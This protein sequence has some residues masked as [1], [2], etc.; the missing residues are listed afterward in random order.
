[1]DAVEKGFQTQLG[2]IQTKT[3]RTLDQ[4]YASIAQSGR[5]KHGEIREWAKEALGLGHGD[6]NT[7][8]KY[9]LA[10]EA[11]APASGSHAAEAPEAKLD[12]LYAGSKA[13]LRPVHERVMAA[14]GKF[15]PFEI[16]PKKT[17]L[18]LRRQ[19]QFAMVGPG[20]RGRLEV[21]LNLKELPA[22]T[23]LEAQ[24][25][26]GMCQYKV[27]LTDAKQVDKELIGWLKQAYERAA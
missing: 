24:A 3:G 10:R 2:N 16:A 12:E 22:S 9:Y 20:T 6:A 23:R 4:L 1:M 26:G 7:L 11:G 15:G 5:R 27:F 14:I 18:S 21:G 8:A 19:K 25:L 13:S 17:Y